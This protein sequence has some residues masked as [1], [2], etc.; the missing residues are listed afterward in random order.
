M[1]WKSEVNS[2]ILQMREYRKE[3]TAGGGSGVKV[4]A[5]PTTRTAAKAMICVPVSAAI[6]FKHLA[7]TGAVVVLA[8]LLH[9]CSGCLSPV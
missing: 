7:F 9:G 1:L 8:F 2:E 5:I 6:V 3:E 4:R